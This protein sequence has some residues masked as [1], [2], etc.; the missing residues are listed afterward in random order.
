MA[1]TSLALW[2]VTAG[3][4]EEFQKLAARDGAGV[5]GD[6]S[7]FSIHFQFI[8]CQFHVS[9]EHLMSSCLQV[10]SHMFHVSWKGT[11]TEFRSRVASATFPFRRCGGTQGGCRRHG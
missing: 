9:G 10:D 11:M 1:R 3:L 2:P 7:Q 6:M 4:S 8:S 5:L